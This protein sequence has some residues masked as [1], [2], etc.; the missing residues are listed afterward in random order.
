M[1]KRDSDAIMATIMDV[2]GAR[3][4]VEDALGLLNSLNFFGSV[5]ENL[6]EKTATI[7]FCRHRKGRHVDDRQPQQNLQS[8]RNLD[9]AISKKRAQ[10]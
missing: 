5:V 2:S 9:E 7:N 4:T 10:N 1:E 6:V 3:D 8:T